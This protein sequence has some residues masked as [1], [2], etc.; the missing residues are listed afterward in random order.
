MEYAEHKCSKIPWNSIVETD[1]GYWHLCGEKAPEPIDHCPF[2]DVKLEK[3]R[4][5]LGQRE[6]QRCA[7]CRGADE[8]SGPNE[9]A[10]LTRLRGIENAL[11]AGIPR[12]GIHGVT[13][14][15]GGLWV[16][17]SMPFWRDYL[18]GVIEALEVKPK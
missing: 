4:L 15:L 16:N 12:E 2:C 9:D 3:P 11:L 17:E 6:G 8:E 13:G 18:A 5:E 7:T 14:Y 10:E 1:D